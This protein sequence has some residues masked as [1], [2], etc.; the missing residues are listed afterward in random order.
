MRSGRHWR[1]VSPGVRKVPA[2][3][4]YDNF[5]VLPDVLDVYIDMVQAVA[6]R[7]KLGDAL[8]G[9]GVS[10]HIFESASDARKHLE[11]LERTHGAIQ[12]ELFEQ[13]RDGQAWKLMTTHQ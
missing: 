12:H 3:V 10:P 5:T 8:L 2:L 13:A 11:M 9:R 7:A 6:S 1:S 4:D